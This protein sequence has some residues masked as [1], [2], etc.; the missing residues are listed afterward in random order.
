[1]SDPAP[2]LLSLASSLDAAT[3]LKLTPSRFHPFRFS[4]LRGR[5]GEENKH[6]LVTTGHEQLAFGH[7]LHAC[8]GRFFASNELKVILVELLRR[9]DL[10]LGPNGETVGDVAKDGTSFSRPLTMKMHTHIVPDP[11]AKIFFRNRVD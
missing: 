3:S 5:P 11:T 6:Q 4:T 10:A 1:M 9:Y 7:G 8:P 2:T